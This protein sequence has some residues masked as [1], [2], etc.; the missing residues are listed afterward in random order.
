MSDSF[1]LRDIASSYDVI[2]CDVWGVIRDGQA[3]LAP[4]LDA[5]RYYRKAGGIVLLLSNSPRR[6]SS[7]KSHLDELGASG[8]A[9]PAWD[10][11]VTS[12]DATFDILKTMAPGPAFKL[13]PDEDDPLYNG[14]GLEFAS[15]DQAR[16]IS[17]TGLFEWET[18]TVDDYRDLLTEA[19][20]LRLPMVCV[21]P[22]IVVQHEGKLLPCGGA[23][24]ELYEKLGGE[25]IY[26]GKPHPPIYDLAYRQMTERTGQVF[27][28]DQILVI[29]DGPTTDILGATQ[30]G[31]DS[32]FIQSGIGS[33]TIP[34]DAR[35]VAKTLKW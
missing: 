14:S 33:E 30:E 19:K 8:L 15:L 16:F 28:K 6:S 12:G 11:I 21:N 34:Q 13:G 29:G 1:Q 22:D 2:L 7:L 23:L 24:A 32:L 31:L 25:T 26:A 20:L 9:T 17:C 18:E 3:L 27:E 4:A 10:G 5:L 35:Y